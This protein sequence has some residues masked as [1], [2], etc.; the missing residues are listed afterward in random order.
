[1][2]SFHHCVVPL[3]HG[4]R[5]N[6]APSTRELSSR[7]RLRESILQGGNGTKVRILLNSF[8]HCVVS[9]VSPAGSVTS[10]EKDTQSFS[11][12]LG[13][14]TLPRGGRLNEAPS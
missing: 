6:E 7:A 10:R 12:T 8:H 4:G 5:L 13:F 9:L 1:M 3:P 2:N 11:N 14:A